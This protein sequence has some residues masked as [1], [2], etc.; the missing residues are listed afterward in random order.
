M[1]NETPNPY[2][3]PAATVEENI[4]RIRGNL[5]RGN[6]Q[7]ATIQLR[8]GSLEAQ[9]IPLLPKTIDSL[10]VTAVV[11]TICSLV[12]G[13]VWALAMLFS[14]RPTKR[15][16]A[17]VITSHDHP[18]FHDSIQSLRDRAT[19]L[20]ARLER[21]EEELQQLRQRKEPRR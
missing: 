4:E 19:R 12:L 7:F 18:K 2:I 20:E 14:E 10:K 6:S 16:M 1:V 11:L 17:E 5:E 3:P 13:A 8:L 15:D 21:A 9:I